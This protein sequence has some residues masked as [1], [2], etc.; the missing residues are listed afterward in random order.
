MAQ[1]LVCLLCNQMIL[2]SRLALVNFFDLKKILR[3]ILRP[4]DLCETQATTWFTVDC[5]ECVTNKTTG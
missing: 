1:W 2:G 3:K 4:N 5:S